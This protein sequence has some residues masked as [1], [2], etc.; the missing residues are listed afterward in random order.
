MLYAFVQAVHVLLPTYRMQVL[1][2]LDLE[3]GQSAVPILDAT[4]PLGT[5]QGQ[6]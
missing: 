5:A 2:A 1:V 4:D 6:S 3:I